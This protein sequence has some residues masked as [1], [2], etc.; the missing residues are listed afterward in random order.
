MPNCYI[1]ITSSDRPFEFDVDNNDRTLF[2]V[3][4]DIMAIWPNDNLEEDLI[5][6][7]QT[8]GVPLVLASADPDNANTFIG[9]A[10]V[11]PTDDGPY[12]MFI[13]QPG[14]GTLET[15]NGTKI[16]QPGIQVIVV[17]KPS[18]LSRDRAFDIWRALDGTRNLEVA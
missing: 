18:I 10:A 14:F 2:S 5:A 8:A 13:S 17:G 1:E 15:H 7:C 4:F 11:F 3:N 16:E 9:S 6:I 12:T